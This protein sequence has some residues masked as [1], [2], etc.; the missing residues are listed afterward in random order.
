LLYGVVVPKYAVVVVF[1]Q[2]QFI[3]NIGCPVVFVHYRFNYI[4]QAAFVYAKKTAI[5]CN[6]LASSVSSAAIM[7]RG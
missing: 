7:L 2:V 6:T 1:I 5:A 3:Y 4:L